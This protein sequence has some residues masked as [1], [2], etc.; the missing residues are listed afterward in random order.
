MKSKKPPIYLGTGSTAGAVALLLGLLSPSPS[1]AEVIAGWDTFSGTGA[2]TPVPAPVTATDIS[3]SFVTTTEQQAWNT[4]DERGASS[5]GTWGTSVGPPAADTTVGTDNDQNLELPNA[6]TGGTITMTITNSSGTDIQLDQFHMDTLAFRP[7]AARTYTLEVLEG[8]AIT[9]GN[10]YSSESQEI[11]SQGGPPPD[12]DQ[13]DDVDLD[14]TFLEDSTLEAGGTVQFLLSFSGGDGDGSGGHDLWV[15]NLAV[16]SSSAD[17]NKLAVTL[18]PS[19]AT[20]GTDFSVTVEAQDG[21]GSPLAGGLSQDTQILITP[22]G[23]GILSGKNAT[24]PAGS[25]SVELTLQYTVAEDITLV[26]SQL[27]GDLLAPSAESSTITINA[28]PPSVLTV[29]FSND[30]EMNDPVGNV[31]FRVNDPA[32]V[33]EVF[34]I[35]RDS[36]GNF[37]AFETGA[38]FSLE[39]ISGGLMA[40]D[41]VDNMDGSATFTAAALGTANIRASVS[42][43]PD[44]NSGLITVEEPQFRWTAGNGAWGVGANWL[45]GILPTFDNTTDLYFYDEYTSADQIFLSGN[46][47]VRSLNFTQFV[48][49]TAAGGLGIRYVQNN[50]AQ[51]GPRN[52]TIDTDSVEDPAMINVAAGAEANINLGNVNDAFIPDN[53]EN[54]GDTI[55]ADDL[56]ITHLG[57]G[58]L[59]FSRPIAETEGS[60]GVTIDSTSTGTVVYGGANTYTGTTTV[61]G[62][63]LR[64]TGDSIAD[65]ASLVIDG[66]VVDV[67]MDERVA[68]LTLGGTAQ[69]DGVYG[70]SNSAAPVPDD[71]NFS[72]TGTITVGPP[73]VDEGIV[74]SDISFTNVG[75]ITITFTSPTNVDVYGSIEED[76]FDWVLYDEDQPPGTYVDP[77]ATTPKGFYILVPTGDPAP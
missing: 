69:P 41:L 19:N 26:A 44:G 64:L 23:S 7:K 27:S 10:V 1:S 17:S 36:V 58:N 57:T 39:N 29:E 74:I 43:L 37:I 24:I 46:R 53:S 14:L 5:D 30:P 75:E 31:S 20:A 9:A 72:G 40:S 66:G 49:P 18:T 35:S 70:S 61:N 34:A 62:G 63:V 77:F 50:G 21:S 67:A 52:L 32:D 8:G 59:I 54:Y 65:A 11:K 2:V 16:T 55:L 42:G 6:T 28:G 60:K 3:A 22:S 25:N 51:G 68:G 71:V 15:D 45:D 47:I 56:L 12:N 13:G 76:G 33:L 38:S 73:P 4:V 48:D